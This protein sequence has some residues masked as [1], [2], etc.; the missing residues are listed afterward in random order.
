MMIF[1]SLDMIEYKEIQRKNKQDSPDDYLGLLLPF[2]E[3]SYD[4]ASFGFIGNNGFKLVCIKKIENSLQE[5]SS[6]IKLK[7]VIL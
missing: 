4:I 6:E 3:Y 1:S 5:S 7:E 2:Y